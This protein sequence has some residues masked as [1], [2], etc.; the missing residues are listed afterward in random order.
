MNALSAEKMSESD[1]LEKARHELEATAQSIAA[2]AIELN[3]VAKDLHGDSEALRL[4]AIGLQAEAGR[5]AL[6]A[7]SAARAGEQVACAARENTT[8]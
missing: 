2:I 1:G 5:L 7:L 8:A 6:A 3:S 4:R